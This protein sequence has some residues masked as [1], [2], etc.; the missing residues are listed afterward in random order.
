MSD[1][2]EDLLQATYAARDAY[3]RQLGEVDPFVLTHLIN[4]AFMGGPKWP[5]LRQAMRVIRNGSHTIIVSDGLAD[6]FDENP[7]PNVGFGLEVLLETSDA[8]EGSVQN[9]WPFWIAYDVAQ[10]FASHGGVRELIDELGMVSMELKARFGPSELTTPAGRIGLLFGVP[11][12]NLQTEWTFPAGAVKVV[13][14]KVLHPQELTV[15]VDEGEAG[16]KRLAKLFAKDR[17]HHISS[18]SRLS[19]I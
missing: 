8:I 2:R 1:S 7:E 11:G 3:L 15:A 10:Q 19:V 16:R 18:A 9:D 14:I 13:T 5:N 17:T 6:P 4:P 12:P